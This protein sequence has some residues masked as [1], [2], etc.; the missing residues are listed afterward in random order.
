MRERKLRTREEL[1]EALG[2][3]QSGLARVCEEFG[4][5]L[6]VVYGSY[7]RGLEREGSDVDV[8]LWRRGQRGEPPGEFSL[9]LW[10]VLGRGEVN[11]VPL[12]RASALLA[13]NAAEGGV[14][15]YEASPDSYL[16]FRSLAYRRSWDERKHWRRQREYLRSKY[17]SAGL[18]DC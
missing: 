6:L 11:V 3:D 17:G 7:A 13:L 18:D 10:R 5:E 8:L 12:Q 4:V 9:R 16:K 2:A 14:A 1:I 15:L